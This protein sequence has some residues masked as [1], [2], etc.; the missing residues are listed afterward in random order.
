MDVGNT[1][2]VTQCNGGT[3]AIVASIHALHT[4]IELASERSRLHAYVL[5]TSTSISALPNIL[6][7]P[8]YYS[9]STLETKLLDG[10]SGSLL[11]RVP[12]GCPESVVCSPLLLSNATVSVHYLKP[13]NQ[14]RGDASWSHPTHIAIAHYNSQRRVSFTPL[15]QR[16]HARP[17]IVMLPDGD[18]R[19]NRVHRQECL[20]NLRHHQLHY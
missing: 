20:D 9:L 19:Q 12:W 11:L 10:W 5:Y 1:Q 17:S 3:A 13:A 18:H 6:P 7:P 2:P 14:L 8:L 16:Q 15:S 4:R